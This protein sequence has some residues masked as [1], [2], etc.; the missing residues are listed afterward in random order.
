[1]KYFAVI[2]KKEKEKYREKVYILR[3]KVWGQFFKIDR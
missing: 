1:M 3:V 2:I